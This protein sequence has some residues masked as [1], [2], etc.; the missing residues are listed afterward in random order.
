VPLRLKIC[1]KRK[2]NVASSV[3]AEWILAVTDLFRT[4]VGKSILGIYSLSSHLCCQWYKQL[5]LSD[6]FSY[7]SALDS[8]MFYNFE[9]FGHITKL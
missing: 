5:K 4:S 7:N 3:L 9:R 6:G 1:G 2:V 8:D